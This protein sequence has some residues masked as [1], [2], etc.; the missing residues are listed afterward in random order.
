MDK[1]KDKILV[2]SS[3][4]L[5][6]VVLNFFAT[7][8]IFM[9]IEY[10]KVGGKDNYDLLNKLQIQQIKQLVEYYKANPQMMDQQATGQPE[11]SQAWGNGQE[12]ITP[13]DFSSTGST[14]STWTQQ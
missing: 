6:L 10:S 1:N 9:Q 2:I 13:V 4:I 8:F 7:Y 5:I 11:G 12:N 14:T 3:A